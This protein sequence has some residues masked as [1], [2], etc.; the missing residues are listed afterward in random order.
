MVALGPDWLLV[1]LFV[2]LGNTIKIALTLCYD[3]ICKSVFVIF[4]GCNH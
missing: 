3:I 1:T 4:D 2:N